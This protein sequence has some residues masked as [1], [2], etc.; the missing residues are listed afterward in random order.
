MSSPIVLWGVSGDPP[1]MAL[2]AELEARAVPHHVLDQRR[3]HVIGVR[4]AVFEPR[5]TGNLAA[6]G[7]GFLQRLLHAVEGRLVDQR[8]DQR[9]AFQR[10]AD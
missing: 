3:M 10:I 1:L 7:G 8:T 6:M 4:M 9:L 2:L 5:A